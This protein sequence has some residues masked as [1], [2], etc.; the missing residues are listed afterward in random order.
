MANNQLIAGAAKVASKFI[1]VG[2]E[3]AKG[4][5]STT[6]QR[7]PSKTEQTNK[8]YQ[9]RVNSLMGKMK[10]NIDFTSF[11][12]QETAAMRT[13]LANERTKY[14]DAATMVANMDDTTSPEYMEQVDIMN[15]VNN[16]FTNLA[17]QLK[18]YKESKVD[19]TEN[20]MTGA[21][22]DGNPVNNTRENLAIYGFLDSDGDG[23]NDER[24]NVPFSIQ[25]GGNLGFEIDGSVRLW[26]DHKGPIFKDYKFGGELLKGNEA[27]FN[28]GRKVGEDAQ[29]LYRLELQQALGNQD[30]L[31]SFIYDFNDN[32][33]TE[34]LA[35]LWEEN[36]DSPEVLQQV[37][38][39]A[40][41]RLVQSRV[42]VGNEGYAN[43][44]AYRNRDK[45]K[46]YSKVKD[47]VDL[48]PDNPNAD[49]GAGEYQKWIN[50]DKTKPEIYIYIGPTPG[51]SSNNLP[52]QK[53][54]GTEINDSGL[55]DDIKDSR[56]NDPTK[57]ED[58]KAAI[59]KA[60]QGSVKRKNY[61][62]TE[63]GDEAY[64]KE[65]MRIYKESLNKAKK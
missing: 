54:D 40:I 20:M 30:T 21:I 52:E 39:Q 41:D 25:Q 49:K 4:F 34:D 50:I 6:Y 27:V 55:S 19:F 63:E 29:D 15:G 13:F 46:G 17:A 11:S 33:K 37:R 51:G 60:A 64:K 1:D 22:S 8:A 57:D 2:A 36:P 59:M 23:I 53:G 7:A 5:N 31:R 58:E 3:V 45:F 38:Q 42:A 44:Q 10:T 43:R 65:V 47:T 35:K 61:P 48:G 26:N 9:D 62:E 28:A 32:F 14:A 24:L 12:P 56:V 18:S 16:S